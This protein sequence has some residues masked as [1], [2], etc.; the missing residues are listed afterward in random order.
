MITLQE[1]KQKKLDQKKKT[2]LNPY[3]KKFMAQKK[4]NT[5]K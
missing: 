4:K 2:N 1:N 3:K 5:K